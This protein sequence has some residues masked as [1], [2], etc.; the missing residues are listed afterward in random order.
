[1]TQE[2]RT[3]TRIDVIHQDPPD[4]EDWEVENDTGG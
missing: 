1:M 4:A 2:G 3:I